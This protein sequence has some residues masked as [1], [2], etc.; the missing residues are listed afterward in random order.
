[1]TNEEAFYEDLIRSD[2]PCIRLEDWFKMDHS[3]TKNDQTVQL[4]QKRTLSSSNNSSPLSSSIEKKHDGSDSSVYQV[5]QLC[6]FNNLKPFYTLISASGPDHCK[7]F[8]VELRLGEMEVYYGTGNSKKNAQRDA[9]LNALKNTKLKFPEKKKRSRK[10]AKGSSV[11]EPPH[12]L[13][14]SELNVILQKL[15]LEAH[16]EVTCHV[17]SEQD[18]QTVFQVEPSIK[19]NDVIIIDNLSSDENANNSSQD[20]ISPELPP[21]TVFYNATVKIGGH[22]YSGAGVTEQ[23]AR[24]TAAQAALQVLLNPPPS[25]ASAQVTNSIPVDPTTQSLPETLKLLPETSKHEVAPTL[26]AVGKLNEYAAKS[27]NKVSYDLVEQLGSSHLPV[28]VIA[29]KLFASVHETEP[30]LVSVAQSN[31]KKGAKNEAAEEML[32]KLNEATLCQQ[33]GQITTTS[34]N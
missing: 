22:K 27:R 21:G 2:N 34:P 25:T 19:D 17:L 23:E 31:T 1:M 4:E 11:I 29:C 3:T 20:E 13:P 24:Q 9:A 33:M 32:K 6:I 7:E 15:Q 14:E 16:W 30:Y 18:L 28:F 12:Q 10:K 26:T 5:A 8:H